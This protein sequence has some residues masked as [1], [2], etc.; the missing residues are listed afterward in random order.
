MERRQVA[1]RLKKKK[2]QAKKDKESTSSHVGL[3]LEDYKEHK[4][5]MKCKKINFF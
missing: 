3:I 4:R 1:K 2:K 5:K